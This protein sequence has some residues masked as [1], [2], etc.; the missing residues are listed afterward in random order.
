MDEESQAKPN[1]AR[2][3]FQSSI[4]FKIF[5]AMGAIAGG[6]TL[7]AAVAAF[8][9]VSVGG[10]IGT[11]TERRMPVMAASLRL[12]QVAGDVAAVAPLLAT[13]D[14]EK[15]RAE[16]LARIAADRKHL[17]AL[18]GELEANGEGDAATELRG[19]AAT[20]FERIAAI[21][22]TAER[23]VASQKER[24]ELES[25][26]QQARER[27][28][29]LATPFAEARAGDVVAKIK[30]LGTASP[31]TVA[32]QSTVI[33][34]GD[35]AIYGNAM[36]ILASVSQGVAILNE[37]TFAGTLK[38][39][40]AVRERFYAATDPAGAALKIDALKGTDIANATYAV[41]D[42][43]EGM[44][45]LFELREQ[46]IEMS[47][48]AAKALVS[49]REAAA[50]FVARVDALDA[51]SQ[52][53]SRAAASEADAAVDTGVTLV[54]AIALAS[55][56]I[57]AGIAWFYVGRR[58]LSRLDAFAVSMR[59]I[60]AGN[61]ETEIPPAR[62]D[63]IG[64][65]SDALESFR[66]AALDAREA[67]KREAAASAAREAEKRAAMANL[68]GDFEASIGGVV[69]DIASAASELRHAS[70]AMTE[71][72]EETRRQTNSA[73]DA[74]GQSASSVQ[75]VASAT[76]QL[77]SSTEEIARRVGE[78]ARIA[79]EAGAQAERTDACVKSLEAAAQRVGDVVSL[80][81]AIAGQ[82]NLLALNATIEA[83][84]AGD[85][86][87]GFAVVASEVKALATQTAKATEE[88]TQQIESIRAATGDTSGAI[89][90]IAQTIARMR[91]IATAVSAAVEEQT[92]ATRGIGRDLEVA[93]DGASQVSAMI[94]GVNEAAGRTGAVAAEVS[95]AAARFARMG[96][97]LQMES[98]RFVATVR[99]A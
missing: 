48:Q 41:L 27:F 67:D 83:A 61:L 38:E 65:L 43:G 19:L 93:S 1:E 28:A 52:A 7:A 73:A 20:V 5:L 60:A 59:A 82:T 69:R 10:T 2:A 89:S 66:A 54:A 24:R 92:A 8:L 76:T 9:L 37:A 4:R 90:V 80:I 85:A 14:E 15:A 3:A 47:S 18:L 44:R 30:R 96:E 50:K 29:S 13:V 98:E 88:I 32:A 56:L 77:S 91:E 16:L 53:A 34:G 55:L 70:G 40:D 23:R 71:A 6:T 39:V 68:A 36:K 57:A 42:F 45:N 58:V 79:E 22:V 64:L 35:F 86:G 21:D 62:A 25:Q 63:E 78:S 75:S 81:S 95:Q 87:K 97:A 12:A 46:E 51:Q 33:A 26:L 72:A 94:G 49:G 99:Q 74:V 17:D 11:M 84:R 31:E